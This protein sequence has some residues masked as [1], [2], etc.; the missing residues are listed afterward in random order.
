MAKAI[1]PLQIHVILAA[2][3]HPALDAVLRAVEGGGDVAAFQL[4]RFGDMRIV[5]LHRAD[6]IKRMRQ[7]LIVDLRQF[8]GPAGGR[9]GLSR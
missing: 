5:G 1:W 4:Q 2:D 3:R 7:D 6:R 8:R 9:R